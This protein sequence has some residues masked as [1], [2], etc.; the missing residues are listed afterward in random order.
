ML[1]KRPEDRFQNPPELL[2]ALIQIADE[3]GIRHAPV[4][5]P[6]SWPGFAPRT[7]PWRRHLPWAVPLVLLLATVVG[8]ELLLSPGNQPTGWQ[9]PPEIDLAPPN[10]NPSKSPLASPANSSPNRHLPK[11]GIPSDTKVPP[12]GPLGE[13]PANTVQGPLSPEAVPVEPTLRPSFLPD[14]PRPATLPL[15]P[16]GGDSPTSGP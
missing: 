16:S 2:V 15:I 11:P 9:R 14:T 13:I 12:A 3:L 5:V 8:I 7:K 4:L 10:N 1:S 6:T